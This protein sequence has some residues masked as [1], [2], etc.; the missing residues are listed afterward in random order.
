M[1]DKAIVIGDSVEAVVAT[2]QA[3]G[4]TIDEAD[5]VP[6]SLLTTRYSPDFPNSG[7]VDTGRAGFVV[8]GDVQE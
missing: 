2:A 7:K 1:T 3:R 8:I 6:F 5:I 4:I